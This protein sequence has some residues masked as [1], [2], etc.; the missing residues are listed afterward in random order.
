[1][2]ISFK[3]SRDFIIIQLNGSLDTKLIRDIE[4]DFE[5]ILS[6]YPTLN[7]LLNM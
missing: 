6:Q 2:T 1:M 3:K 5:Q 7:I 4:E